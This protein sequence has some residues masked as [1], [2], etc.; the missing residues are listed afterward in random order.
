MESICLIESFSRLYLTLE[1]K[2]Y[3]VFLISIQ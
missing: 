1:G 3:I 2:W